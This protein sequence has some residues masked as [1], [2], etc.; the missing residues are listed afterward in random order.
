MGDLQL[1]AVRESPPLLTLRLSCIQMYAFWVISSQEIVPVVKGK[2]PFC[3][4]P[5]HKSAVEWENDHGALPG[6]M[7]HEAWEH[8]IGQWELEKNSWE[9]KCFF[10]SYYIQA[11]IVSPQ[12]LS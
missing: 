6:G 5:P 4:S 1:C 11:A 3:A 8:M 9:L 12:V 7:Q 10:F 2:Y